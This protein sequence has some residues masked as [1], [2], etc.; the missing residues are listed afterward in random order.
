MKSLFQHMLDILLIIIF[1]FMFAGLIKM[2]SD[3]KEAR[4]VFASTVEAVQSSYYD[5]ETIDKLNEQLHQNYPESWKLSITEVDSVSTRRNYMVVL[6]YEI[7]MPFFGLTKSG[8]LRG[9]AR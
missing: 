5:Q 1:F 4:D 7:E 3:L 6:H 2:E 9:Y 8:E